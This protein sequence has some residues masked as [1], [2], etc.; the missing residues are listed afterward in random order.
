MRVDCVAVVDFH[1][2]WFV[3]AWPG[4]DVRPRPPRCAP[5]RYRVARRSTDITDETRQIAHLVVDCGDSR[6]P[7]RLEAMVD[8]LGRN[9]DQ[10]FVTQ[11]YSVCDGTEQV[12]PSVRAHACTALCV[13]EGQKL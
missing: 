3:G 8:R 7:S 9:L 13:N 12:R 6:I 4:S 5:T 2:T 10:S 1:S 11:Q